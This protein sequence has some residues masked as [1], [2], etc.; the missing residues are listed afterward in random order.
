METGK[1]A[2]MAAPA[3]H[4]IEQKQDGIRSSVQSA[5]TLMIPNFRKLSPCQVLQSRAEKEKRSHSNV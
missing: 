5:T 3:V 1:L 2:P 4:G